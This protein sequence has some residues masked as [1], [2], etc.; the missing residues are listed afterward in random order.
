MYAKYRILL[1]TT[2]GSYYV[3]ASNSVNGLANLVLDWFNNSS[4][5]RSVYDDMV[6]TV[7]LMKLNPDTGAYEHD[8]SL[9]VT[10]RKDVLAKVRLLGAR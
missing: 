5:G 9:P 10:D 2:R 4:A 7:S 1:Q 8:A 6:K 3:A